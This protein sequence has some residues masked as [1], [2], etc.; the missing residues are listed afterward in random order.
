MRDPSAFVAGATGY[1]GRALV[2][3]LVRR[4]VRTV[5]H[6]RADSPRLAEWTRRFEE[7]GAEVDASPFEGARLER[8]LRGLGPT[9][10]FFVVGTTRARGRRSG[11]RET[12]ASVDLALAR[13][14]IG[15][16]RALPDPARFVYLS[17]LG[18]G[19]SARGSYL[20]ARWGVEQALRASGLPHTIARPALVSGPDRDE[21]R[22]LERLGAA[23]ADPPLHLLGRL[24]AP[25]LR[26]RWRSTDAAE[27]AFA[28]ARAAFAH[29][30]AGRV[31]FGDE[32][33]YET[34]NERAVDAPR[35]RRDHGR[36]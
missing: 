33:R 26:D 9:H 23:L 6:V 18:S 30:T 20:R 27:L 10:L 7:G 17:S 31:L 4:G 13:L 35:S 36:H 2:A 34:P 19:P 25:G 32:L 1:V 16:L 14:F 3:E 28:L 21:R 22:L 15:A 24:G 11:G 8:T 5:A 29:T 12:Y